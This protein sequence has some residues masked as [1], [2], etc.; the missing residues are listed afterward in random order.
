MGFFL[1]NNLVPKLALGCVLAVGYAAAFGAIT[2]TIFALLAPL[3]EEHLRYATIRSP[4]VSGLLGTLLLSPLLLSG[5][6]FG[7]IP[8]EEATAL[9]GPEFDRVMSDVAAAYLPP[10][11]ALCI[12]SLVLANWTFRRQSRY[13]R[14]GA[15]AW[16]MF[17]FI[18]GV[19]GLVA[20][21]LHR[22]WPA[23]ET[24]EK[25]G[26]S[27]PR[28]RDACLHCG[29]AFPPPAMKGIEIFA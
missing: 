12:L 1:R 4:I 20:Y 17:V 24:C 8:L 27:S 10:L 11:A 6:A 16:A 26:K 28:D 19:P 3:W 22:H 15:V 2:A 21:L 13:S 23:S 7:M 14:H 25:C 9:S 5:F 29:T 18:W